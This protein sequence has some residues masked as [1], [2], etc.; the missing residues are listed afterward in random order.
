VI[1]PIS[2]A[3]TKNFIEEPPKRTSAKSI[4]IIVIELFTDLI[5]VSVSARFCII[6]N[7][8]VTDGPLI[9]TNLIEN[10]DRVVD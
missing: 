7:V 5:S 8:A 10:N 1:V 6:G 9:F 2:R 4:K 3:A